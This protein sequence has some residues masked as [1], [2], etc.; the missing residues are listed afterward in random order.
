MSGDLQA[1]EL[2]DGRWSAWSGTVQ[3]GVFTDLE[4]A[5][6]RLRDLAPA[7]GKTTIH[8]YPL[9]GPVQTRVIGERSSTPAESDANPATTVLLVDD[10]PDILELARMF[11]EMDGLKVNFA[12]DGLQALERYAELN[13]PP[14]PAVV[15]LDN[16]MPGLTG[17]QVA[18]QMLA[19][20]PGQLIVLFSAFLD[21]DT[22]DAATAV[23]VAAC[24]SKN[25]L[26]KLPKIIR[27][28]I[29]AA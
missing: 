27:S 14:Q 15:V 26:R 25:D 23:G 2:K 6:D 21:Q 17:V 19:V 13:P 29:P 20:H 11:L 1:L 8:V 24:V 18:E 4:A 22:Q 7:L 28:L 3:R 10:E 5:I 12:A 16:R 9:N